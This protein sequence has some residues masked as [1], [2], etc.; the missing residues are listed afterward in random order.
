MTRSNLKIDNFISGLLDNRFCSNR[1]PDCD[2]ALRV[3]KLDQSPTRQNAKARDARVDKR[4]R[5]ESVT[6]ILSAYAFLHR[7][8][9]AAATTLP[10][11]ARDVKGG[12][13][14]IDW[15]RPNR[16]TVG[17]RISPTDSCSPRARATDKVCCTRCDTDHSIHQSRQDRSGIRH[18]SNAVRP[19]SVVCM[20]SRKKNGAADRRRSFRNTPSM[21]HSTY[22]E[23]TLSQSRN[24][25]PSLYCR[26]EML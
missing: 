12:N 7:R 2:S 6:P 3:A 14:P 19:R 21:P 25:L 26:K 9:R 5:S 20:P 24:D 16:R 13:S 11:S 15:T 8:R 23:G 4:T 17:P 10:S 22:V 1:Q 18:A